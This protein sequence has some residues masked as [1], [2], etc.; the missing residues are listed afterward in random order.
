MQ[1]AYFLSKTLKNAFKLNKKSKNYS[2]IP[3]QKS[4][5]TKTP[6]RLARNILK[7]KL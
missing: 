2:R 6:G 7:D 1:C 3:A 5:Q 4:L